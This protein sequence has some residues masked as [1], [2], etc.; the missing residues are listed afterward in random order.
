MA[1]VRK[2]RDKSNMNMSGLTKTVIVCGRRNCSRCSH[3]RPM[4][5]FRVNRWRDEHKTVPAKFHPHCNVCDKRIK[6]ASRRASKICEQ[7]KKRGATLVSTP[8]GP[9]SILRSMPREKLMEYELENILPVSA[10]WSLSDE[11]YDTRPVPPGCAGCWRKDLGA[12]CCECPS[13]A[14]EM[15]QLK[16]ARKRTPGWQQGLAFA[17]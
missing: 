10:G 3:W 8:Q 4:T 9:E 5:D 15:E 13:R 1:K 17:R 16:E 7:A 6:V 14:A 2:V 11:D 12:V